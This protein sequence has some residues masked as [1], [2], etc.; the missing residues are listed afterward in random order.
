MLHFFFILLFG[1]FLSST[2][3]ASTGDNN[4]SPLMDFVW[5]TVNVLVLLAII[6]KFAKTPVANALNNNAKSA[7]KI[8]DEAI[9]AE[10]K[11]N[12]NLNEM[13]LKILSLE[14]EALEMVENAKKDAE[15]EKKLIIEEGKQEIKRMTEQANFNLKQERRKVEDEL[16][17]WIAEESVR[18]AE[19]K[20]KE[21]MNKEHQKNLVGKYVD[22][23]KKQG[24]FL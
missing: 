15:S 18:L 11:N 4:A 24:E 7:K 8:M 1:S 10:E 19:E 3:F 12:K 22:Q 17:H 6:Y 20:L 23:I 16:K 2:I 21:E 5:K 14:K 13:K 9:E